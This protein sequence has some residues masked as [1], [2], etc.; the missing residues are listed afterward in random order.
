MYIINQLHTTQGCVYNIILPTHP[1]LL[2]FLIHHYAHPL[3]PLSFTPGLKP[4][5]FI[6]PTPVVSLLLPRLHSRTIARTVSSSYSVFVFSFSLFFRF[7]AVRYR[8]NWPSRQLLSARKSTVSYRI[9][10]ISRH[11]VTGAIRRIPDVES[12]RRVPDN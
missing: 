6:S 11:E 1:S 10:F 8:L 3:L 7:C 9:V 12:A 4:T 5:S 2:S